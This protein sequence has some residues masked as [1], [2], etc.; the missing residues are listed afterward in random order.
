MRL[1]PREVL[2]KRGP[3][4]MPATLVWLTILLI[5]LLIARAADGQC[6]GGSCSIG[7]ASQPPS[8][9]VNYSSDDYPAVCRVGGA[10][11]VLVARDEET[12]L[13]LTAYHVVNHLG[14]CLTVRFPATEEAFPGTVDGRDRNNDLASIR[15]TG[16]PSVYPMPLAD[17]VPDSGS[18][19]LAGWGENRFRCVGTKVQE[20][21][22]F[23][24]VDSRQ[25]RFVASSG[26][27]ALRVSHPSRGG[28]SG[29]AVLD[30]DGRLCG[31]LSSTGP[32]R[33]ICMTGSR[34][35]QCGLLRRLI[36]RFRQRLQQQD[37][38]RAGR[39]GA[40][41]QL[42]IELDV[43]RRV[44][45]GAE[46]SKLPPQPGDVPAPVPDSES[47]PDLE[48]DQAGQ[49]RK[50]MRTAIDQLQSEMDQM[51]GELDDLE[52][53]TPPSANQV[54]EALQ[55]DEALVAALA[56]ALAEDAAFQ[57]RVQGAM[58]PRGPAGPAGP[59][60]PKG[61][62]GPEGPQGPPGTA[63]IDPA[64]LGQAI[65]G[66]LPGITVNWGDTSHSVELGG[67]LTLPSIKIRSVTADR[68]V[69]DSETVPLGG[70]VNIQGPVARRKTAN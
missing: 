22:R 40:K 45:R 32:S 29:G 63:S 25:G 19:S 47:A 35:E 58:G 24:L 28:D 51:R 68:Q 26:G 15:L 53:A 52:S 14:K 34:G 8:W 30:A 5:L 7:E 43:D 59:P 44:R 57:Q 12:A 46:Y 1:D 36:D 3:I 48:P 60:G 6:S 11:G 18:I 61:S 62:S 66:Q 64:A 55:S 27:N 41:R 20:A 42:D 23:R 69:L 21:G 39:R 49:S 13:V 2:S 37:E 50:K 31:I 65:V 38:A 70:S 4:E 9:A 33:T 16:R 56:D 67:S 54:A 10:S 17:R